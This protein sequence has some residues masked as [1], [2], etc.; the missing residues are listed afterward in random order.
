[1]SEAAVRKAESAGGLRTVGL[2][3]LKLAQFRNYAALAL[4]L[5]PEPVVLT[6]PNGAGKTNLLEA[7]SFLSPGRGL[8]RAKLTDVARHPGDGSWAV[9]ATLSG[10]DG[11]TEIGTGIALS[12][13]GPDRQRSVRVNRAPAPSSQTLLDHCR[14][15]WLTPA[16]DGLFTGAASDR[17]RFLDR[18]VLALDPLHGERVNAY[19]RA[20]RNRNR[21]FEEG[22]SDARWFEAIEAQMA[23]FAV[24]IAAARNECVALLRGAIAAQPADGPFPAAVIA[25]DG[26]VETLLATTTATEAED[27]VRDDLA[28][29]RPAD[30]AAG[31]SRSG[32]HLSDLVVVHGPKAAPAAECSTGEQKALLIGIVLAHARLTS[33]LTGDTPVILLDEVAAH[34]DPARR[35]ALFGILLDL[36]AQ[37]WMTGTEPAPFAALVGLAQFFRVEDATVTAARGEAA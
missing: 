21:L 3:G 8:R 20:M 32:P 13:D 18:L 4:R 10:P 22:R 1:M 11:E 29:G 36:G 2:S 30:R 37:V 24:A 27:R 16:M 19:D 12:A 33:Q 9:A 15:V 5:G 26:A 35:A 34:L 23:E 7:L 17:R 14:V 28:A 6:G 25:I 31:R